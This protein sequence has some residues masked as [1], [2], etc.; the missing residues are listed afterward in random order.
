MKR[1]LQTSAIWK[2]L[3]STSIENNLKNKLLQTNQRLYFAYCLS[4]K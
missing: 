4:L 1:Y 3:N 2:I